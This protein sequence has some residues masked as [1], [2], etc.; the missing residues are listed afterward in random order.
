LY[1]QYLLDVSIK[2]QFAAFRAGFMLVFNDRIIKIFNPQ[3]L[4]LLTVGTPVVDLRALETA[5]TYESYSPHDDVI[6]WLWST[7]HS[8]SNEQQKKFLQFCTGTTR[9]PILGLGRARFCV[10]RS[11]G[12]DDADARMPVAHTCH[13]TL[14]LPPYSSIDILRKRL[15]WAIEESAL[16]FGLV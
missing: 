16:G 3:E 4:E 15:V 11:G 2:E 12:D 8:L 7:V 9:A 10:Q 13:S 6:K 5:T 1:S 14:D